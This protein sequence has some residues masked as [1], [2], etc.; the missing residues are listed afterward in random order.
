MTR[1]SPKQA[2]AAQATDSV[3]GKIAAKPQ[4]TIVTSTKRAASNNENERPYAAIGSSNVQ[5]ARTLLQ[6]TSDKTSTAALRDVTNHHKSDDEDDVR[7]YRQHELPKTSKPHQFQNSTPVQE[8][9][10][11][12]KPNQ[13]RSSTPVQVED[14]D[15]CNSSYDELDYM[16]THSNVP[17]KT[18]T[19][20][21]SPIVS[22]DSL[23]LGPIRSLDILKIGLAVKAE[24]ENSNYF[25]GV[26]L[27]KRS[28]KGLY[29]THGIGKD[30]K[31]IEVGRL[32]DFFV[33]IIYYFMLHH[34]AAE[35]IL[36]QV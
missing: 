25:K 19:T 26:L 33:F 31:K 18:F 15:L 21:T 6:L 24:L 17:T 22:G 1:N 7:R 28:N 3:R 13:F 23:Y 10:K 12:S 11:I 14:M 35:E 4:T 29:V 27:S 9:P 34:F 5:A 16:N 20:T 2:K 8:L 32:V 30:M 36:V